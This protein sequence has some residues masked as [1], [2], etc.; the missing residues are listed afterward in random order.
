[1]RRI[2][3]LA[4]VVAAAAMLAGGP[5]RAD[6]PSF[7][8]GSVGIYDIDH[9]EKATSFAA[10]YRPAQKLW[11]FKP[12]AGAFVTTERSLYGY[13]GLLVDIYFGRRLV[14]TP[15]TAFGLYDKGNGKDLGSVVEF[16][17]G[18]EL[19]Y[20]FDNR[21]RLGIG[22]H[23]LSNAGIGD[24]NPGTEILSVIFSYPLGSN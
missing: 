21:S 13:A 5:A 1:M 8:S 16:R 15:S 2:N 17:S 19:A 22:F 24:R 12:H 4:T 20:R 10:D 14:L 18:A 7:V 6:D 11:I 3:A 23:H 9:H